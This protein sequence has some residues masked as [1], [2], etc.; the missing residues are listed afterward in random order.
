MAKAYSVNLWES[1]PD[2]ENDDCSTGESFETLEQA[3]ECMFNLD[4]H[5][6]MTYY[7]N[8]PFVELDGPDVHLVVERPGVAKRARQED[9]MDGVREHAMQMGMGLGIHAYNEAMGGDSEEYQASMADQEYE[10]WRRDQRKEGRC[11][12]CGEEG[13]TT[14]HMGCQSSQDHP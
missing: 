1:H 13:Q 9:R 4:K 3:V 11:S 2:Q 14:G 8:T 5:F 6:D 12:D 7:R 10:E